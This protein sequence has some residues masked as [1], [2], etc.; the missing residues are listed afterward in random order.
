LVFAVACSDACASDA[1]QMNE[2]NQK[3]KRIY[4]IGT[5]KRR[6]PLAPLMWGLFAILFVGFGVFRFFEHGHLEWFPLLFGLVAAILGVVS[7]RRVKEL[8]LNC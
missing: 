5:S 4:G 6:M 3:A 7:Y 8:Q 2:M 1:A